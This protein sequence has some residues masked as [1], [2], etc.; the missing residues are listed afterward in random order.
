M[1]IVE[2]GKFLKEKPRDKKKKVEMRLI[3]TLRAF[4]SFSPTYFMIQFWVNLEKRKC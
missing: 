4:V 3:K 1:L 2:I